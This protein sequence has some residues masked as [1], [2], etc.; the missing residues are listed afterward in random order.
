MNV[1]VDSPR[2]HL[3]DE[4]LN[5]SLTLSQLKKIVKQFPN[6]QKVTGK[7]FAYLVNY[8]DSNCIK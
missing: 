7:C 3:N 6:K 4:V 5:D 8:I 1:A 2:E